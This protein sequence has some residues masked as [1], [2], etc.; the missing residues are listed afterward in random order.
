VN[1][2]WRVLVG[3]VREKLAELPA[4]S[5]QCCV[6]SPPYF[7][8]RDYGVAGQ[9]GLERT[10][11]E[12]VAALVEVFAEV[13]RVLA[14]DGV[15]WLNLGSSYFGSTMTGGNNGFNASGGADGFKQARQFRRMPFSCGKR[16]SRSLDDAPACDIGGKAL[17]DSTGVGSFYSGLCDGCLADFQNHRDRIAGSFQ[18]TSRSAQQPS[19]TGRDTALTDCAAEIPDASPLD[20]QESTTL[21]SWLLHRGE[22]SRCANRVSCLSGVRSFSADALVSARMTWVNYTS[23]LKHKDLVPIPWMVALALQADGWYLRS[24]IIWHKPNPM[25]ESVTDRPTK[26]HEY[27]FL[28]TKAERYYYDAEAIA[29]P[30]EGREL[31][32]NSRKL[33]HADRQDCERRDMT[34]NF[35]RNA[36]SV[37]TITTAPYP[38]AHFATFPEALPER[39]I[40]AGSKEGDTVLDPFC[41]SGTT[42]A[43]AMRLGRN[44]IGI[45]LN[46]TYAELSRKRIGSALPMFSQEVPA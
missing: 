25:P 2:T 19:Q 11:A 36:R 34:P 12:F 22:C 30:T 4:G 39:C 17:L 8:L 15:C 5:V 29:E 10:P 20:V 13:K 28:L 26:S 1:T 16:T 24:D 27:V 43:V 45:E 21:E 37:W 31:F 46:P 9:I 18:Q 42:G 14:D 23:K 44:F 38:E 6:T 35:S 7:G 33:V 3:D 32:G 40:K 41:G